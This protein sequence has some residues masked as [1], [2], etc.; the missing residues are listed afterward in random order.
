M[1]IVDK[2]TLYNKD[3]IEKKYNLCKQTHNNEEKITAFYDKD[4]TTKEHGKIK[5]VYKFCLIKYQN[6]SKNKKKCY[7][8]PSDSSAD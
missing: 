7:G 6:Y 8:L 1:C 2:C 4:V 5:Y 3:R